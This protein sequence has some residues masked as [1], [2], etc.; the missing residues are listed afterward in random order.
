VEQRIE[1]V[2]GGLPLAVRTAWWATSWLRGY[3]VTDLLLDAVIGDDATHVVAGLGSLGLRAGAAGEHQPA[4]TLLAG[5]ARVRAE[6]ATGFGVA[7]PVEGDPVGLGGPPEF[8]HAALETGQAVVVPG[9]WIG[10]VPGRVGA[11]VTWHAHRAERRQLPD[12]GEAD[13]TLRRELTGAANALADLDVA[14]WRPEA[15]DRLMNLRH[16]PR[17]APPPGVPERCAELAAR[18]LQAAEIVDI[19]L[20]DEGGAVSASEI[21]ARR[22][23]LRPLDRAARH[24]LVAA[25]SPEAWPQ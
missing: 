15:A 23:A 2:D 21:S 13:R 14:R 24:A 18:A 12:I 17:L 3:V 10:L 1:R 19:A 4:E 20:E 8:N 9:A 11:A 7:L 22:D 6:G 25:G 5:L 16:H